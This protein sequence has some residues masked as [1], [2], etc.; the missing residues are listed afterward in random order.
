MKQFLLML[1]VLSA[2]SCGGPRSGSEMP[3]HSP[4]AEAVSFSGEPLYAKPADSMAV[5]KS[6]SLIQGIRSKPELSEEDYVSM[7]RSLVGIGQFR[8]AVNVYTEGLSAFP[9]SYKLLRHR[10]HRYINLRELDNAID[11]LTR[12]EELIRNEPEVYE[13]DATGKQGATYQHQIWYHIGLYHFLKRNYAAAAEAYEK[14]LATAHT[15]GD[16]AGASDWLYNCYM[17]A[18]EKA[19]AAAVARPFTVDFDIENKDYPYY[20]R[21]LLFNG[22]IKPADLVDES[23][24]IREMNLYEITKLYGLANYYAYQGDSTHAQQLYTKVL[25]S[26]EWQGFAYASAELD[27]RQ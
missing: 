5:M 26:G 7:G 18:G 21:L 25:K 23:K 17:R 9:N 13:Y 6:D 16:K 27:V 2:L 24:D 22:A 1:F 11:D 4:E 8:K 12:A 20:R 14:S 3:A 10:G 19:K 15:G